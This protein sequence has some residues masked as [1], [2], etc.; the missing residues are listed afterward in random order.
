MRLSDETIKDRSWWEEKGFTVPSYD[1]E[2]MV[3]NTKKRPRWIHFGAGNIFRAMHAVMADTLIEKGLM[4]TGIIVVEGYDFEIIDNVYKPFDNLSIL[5]TFKVD[6]SIQ[7]RIVGSV[8]EA[9]SVEADQEEN[10]QRVLEIFTD[11]GLQLATFTITEKGYAVRNITGVLN[12]WVSD[13]CVAGPDGVSSC[14]GRICSLLYARY[15]AGAFPIAMVSTDNCSHNGDKLKNAMEIIA[16]MWEQTGR[17]EKGFLEYIKNPH[18]VSFP[19]TM[20]DK[21]TPAPHVVVMQLLQGLGIENMQGYVT[22]K[23]TSTAPYVNAEETEYLVI[24]DAFPNGRP[25]LSECGIM[26]TDRATVE[27]VENMKVSTCLNPLHTALAIFGCL[28]NYTKISEEMASDVLTRLVADIGYREGMPVV[29]HPGIIDPFDFLDTVV[30]IRL[31]NPFMP[32]SPRRIAT[33]TSQKLHVRYGETIKRYYEKGLNMDKLVLIPLTIAGWFRYLMAINDDGL[34]MII[35]PDPLLEELQQVT[36]TISFG[37]PFESIKIKPLL[38]NKEIFGVDLDEVGLAD[39]ICRYFD[40]LNAGPGAVSETLRK[41][42]LR[43][44]SA[45]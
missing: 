24:E 25:D 22:E 4:D 26:L 9:I 45:L 44:Q 7:K 33:D 21:I 10:K 6:G 27:K 32:D 29:V 3:K 18:K 36:D 16:G 2:S 23:N 17:C 35:S 28:L 37:V 43:W 31:P 38:S 19:I 39:R 11:P 15:L 8:A 42:A 1:R 12:S 5:T 41:Y 14:L 40:E 34:E 13:D 30:Q 20:I